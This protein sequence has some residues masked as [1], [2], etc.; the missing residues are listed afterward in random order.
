VPGLADSEPL[1]NIEALELDCLPEHLIVIGGGYVGL[2]FAQAY[3]RFGSRVTILQQAPQ[4]LAHEDPDVAPN[5]SKYLVAREFPLSPLQRSLTCM[6]GPDTVSSSS[7]EPHTAKRQLRAAIS[8][9][10]PGAHP[11]PQELGWK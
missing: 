4:L 6:V 2:E 11:T 9:L 7:C 10:L 8:L 1:T 5:Y 3:R